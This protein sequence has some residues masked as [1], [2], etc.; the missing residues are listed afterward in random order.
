ML[1]QTKRRI[2][3]IRLLSI[4]S[5][6]FSYFPRQEVI[7]HEK[8]TAGVGENGSG[9]TTFNNMVRLLFGA[10]KFDNGHSLRTFL[11]EMMFLKSMC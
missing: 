10:S 3:P 5:E 2:A 4:E 11:K 1:A 9:K 6:G 7:F 8:I